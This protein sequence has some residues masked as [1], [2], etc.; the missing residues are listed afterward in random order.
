M[1]I[2]KTFKRFANAYGSCGSRERNSRQL[3]ISVEHSPCPARNGDLASA[4]E[5]RRHNSVEAPASTLMS[6]AE[7]K[8]NSKIDITLFPSLLPVRSFHCGALLEETSRIRR[9]FEPSF[10]TSLFASAVPG[11]SSLF[12]IS[13]AYHHSRYRTLRA[14]SKIQT[15][16]VQAGTLL[17][18]PTSY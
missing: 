10:F 3:E 6:H 17:H 14:C 8:R 16:P 1:S 2:C 5:R 15:N 4:R 11:S 7:S 13:T 9:V 12:P 18:T